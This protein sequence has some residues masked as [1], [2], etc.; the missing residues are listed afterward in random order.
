MLFWESW[1]C[2]EL[3]REQDSLGDKSR[4]KNLLV[5]LNSG[6]TKEEISFRSQEKKF[7]FEK[8]QTLPNFDKEL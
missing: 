3:A 8:N 5:I 6:E 2:Y 4:P 7:H 1:P